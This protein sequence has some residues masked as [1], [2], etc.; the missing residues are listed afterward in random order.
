[1]RVLKVSGELREQQPLTVA[2]L[3]AADTGAIIQIADVASWDLNV[4]DVSSATPKVPVHQLL[5]QSPSGVFF[6]PTVDDFW[7]F[8]DIG[9]NFR[10]KTTPDDFEMRGGHRYVWEYRFDTSFGIAWGVAEIR[11][12]AVMSPHS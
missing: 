3:L 7:T 4:F 5:G 1:M 6:P 12:V 2:G 9:Y 11:C 8:D 10:H